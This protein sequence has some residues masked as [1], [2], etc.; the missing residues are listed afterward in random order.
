MIL[1]L[2]FVG[3]WDLFLFSRQDSWDKSLVFILSF[4]P[5]IFL[6]FYALVGGFYTLHEE[7]RKKSIV[8]LLSLPVRC[9]TIT[10]TKLLAVWLESVVF[11]VV[12]FIGAILFNKKANLD[13]IPI[14]VLIQYGLLILI[15]AILVSILSQFSYIIGRVFRR[16]RW[17]ISIWV[18]LLTGWGIFRYYGYLNPFFS[19]VPNIQ[20]NSWFL[21]GIWQYLGDTSTPQTIQIHGPTTTVLLLSFI[22]VFFLGSWVL[23]KYTEV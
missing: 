18:F 22:L 11:I 14:Q 13:P 10:G 3:V 1:L 7:W 20:L 5:I 8:Q 23:K 17:L 2:V 4:I 12:T 21:S 6:P 16:I 19:F 9:I 15:T